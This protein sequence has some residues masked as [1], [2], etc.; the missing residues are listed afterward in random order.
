MSITWQQALQNKRIQYLEKSLLNGGAHL[1]FEELQTNLLKEIPGPIGIKPGTIKKM[2]FAV[3]QGVEVKTFAEAEK[4]QLPLGKKMERWSKERLD[5]S[6][7]K[8][9]KK[10]SGRPGPVH[11]EEDA[12]RSS[13]PLLAAWWAREIQPRL[14]AQGIRG[15]S[16]QLGDSPEVELVTKVKL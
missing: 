8:P 16:W 3:S 5:S 1:P 7:K 14:E 13:N 10:M 15:V 2:A 4:I 11:S 12:P 6:S 9:S